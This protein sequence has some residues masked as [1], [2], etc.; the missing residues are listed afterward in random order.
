[1]KARGVVKT[2]PVK[3]GS[4]GRTKGA[5]RAVDGVDLDIRAGEVL[6]LV[7]ESGC[8]KS[9]L[10]RVLLRLLDAD[11]GT[12]T[13]DGID[14]RAAKGDALR[15]L[16]SQ[17][18]VV[19]QDPFSSLDPRATIGDSI[20]EGLRAH[21]VPQEVAPWPRH[22]GA[23]A[24]RARGLPPPPV[25]PSVLGR[26]APA[27][28]Y[29]PSARSTAPVP[30]RRRARLGPRRVDPE[31]DPEP[32]ARPT[33]PP[34]FHAALRGPRPRGGRAPLRSGGG[35]V[36]RAHRRAGHAR[37]G[38]PLAVASVHRGAHVG[39]A[40]CRSRPRP[41]PPCARRRDSQ[42]AEPTRRLLLPPSLPAEGAGNVRL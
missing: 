42:P 41:H 23:R 24:G 33:A 28:R 9:T 22:R 13:F 15:E 39:G 20:A 27:H 31:P 34:R 26:P 30:R 32:A 29:R 36:P 6:G 11:S 19:F 2:F 35:D 38:I 12:I 3:S 37:S 40:R 18:Q 17:M 14:V 1:M 4:F 7:G 10:G 25:P 8:G 16:R 21:G 5:V